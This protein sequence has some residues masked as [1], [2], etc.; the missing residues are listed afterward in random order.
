MPEEHEIK[1]DA[2][3]KF[4]KGTGSAN[5]GG[6]PKGSVNMSTRIK[7]VLLKET[8][9]R[10]VADVLAEVLVKEALKSPAKMWGFLKEFM[11]RDEGRTDKL[12]ALHGMATEEQA[13]RLRMAMAAMDSTVPEP[14]AE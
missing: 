14:D 1:R 4:L 10:V 13:E 5:P 3:G 11:D 7:A 2:D 12:D 9:G 8:N 6:R